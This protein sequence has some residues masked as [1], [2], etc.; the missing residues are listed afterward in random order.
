[1]MREVSAKLFLLGG[2]PYPL[3]LEYFKF[4]DPNASIELK[5]KTPVGEKEIIPKEFLFTEKVSSS[6]V[7]QQN[8]PPDDYSQGFERGIQIDETWDEAVTFAA[9]EAAE[10]AAEKVSRLI[11]GR[12]N[13]PEQREKVVA[14]AEDFVRLA[15]REKLSQEELEWIVHRKFNPKTPANFH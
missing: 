4:D 10:H 8:L 5:W 7:T 3:S 6:F 2:R 12:E 14:I 1:M 11:R 13:D 15:F 9:L